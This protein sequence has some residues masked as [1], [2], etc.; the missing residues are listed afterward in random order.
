MT[1]RFMPLL[2]NKRLEEL[3]VADIMTKNP[4]TL[5]ENALLSD[6]WS[7]METKGVLHIPVVREGMLVALLTERHLRDAMPSVLLIDDPALRHKALEVTRVAQVWI[8][9]PATACPGDDLVKA[10]RS[11]RHVKA[12]SLP[13][14]DDR[15]RVVGIV[16]SGDLISLLETVLLSPH[17]E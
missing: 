5:D 3:R 12:G 1:Y 10:I 4:V 8:P 17:S 16:T 11:M 13:V 2:A 9:N 6:A 14:V 7:I 15:H